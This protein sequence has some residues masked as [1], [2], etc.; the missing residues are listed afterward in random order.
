[1][2]NLRQLATRQ[3]DYN[4]PSRRGD[5]ALSKNAGKQAWK[6]TSAF[7]EFA[8]PRVWH[9]SLPVAASAGIESSG[10]SNE[11]WFL[12]AWY[13]GIESLHRDPIR[14]KCKEDD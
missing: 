14:N 1:M 13:I 10:V 11:L 5:L 9:G 4:R 8:L 12:S 3:F 6:A 7:P 2:P